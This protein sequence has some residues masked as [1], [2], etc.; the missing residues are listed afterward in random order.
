MF[1]ILLKTSC[2]QTLIQPSKYIF[3][4]TS[5][6]YSK[7]MGRTHWKTWVLSFLFVTMTTMLQ[8]SFKQSGNMQNSFIFTIQSTKRPLRSFT[9]QLSKTMTAP[10]MCSFLCRLP[11]AK[12]R[13]SCS[14]SLRDPSARV[15]EKNF[16][17]ADK[18]DKVK[19]HTKTTPKSK[20]QHCRH[21]FKLF[22]RNTVEICVEKCR[23]LFQTE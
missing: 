5:N 9:E 17:N 21:F 19:I 7:P 6:K 13:E 4:N 11:T 12:S 18:A 3:Q 10:L 20:R 14:K 1:S 2:V 22:Q 15:C 8:C 23:G 16:E